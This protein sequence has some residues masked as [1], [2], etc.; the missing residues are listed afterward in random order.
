MKLQVSWDNASSGR[1]EHRFTVADSFI[2]QFDQPLV[3][4]ETNN[5][6]SYACLTVR[7]FAGKKVKEVDFE[8]SEFA[9]CFDET[10]KIDLKLAILDVCI[11]HVS[12]SKEPPLTILSPSQS[13]SH[14]PLEDPLH[15]QSSHQQNSQCKL[16][17][18]HL[19]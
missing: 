5:V 11:S 18:Q 17:I 6:S 8:L 16:S 10:M 13:K 15:I 4:E 1:F 2:L 9:E 14:P 12:K 7:L 19:R 3:A